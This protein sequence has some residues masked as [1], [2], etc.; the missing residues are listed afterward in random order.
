MCQKA[1]SDRNEKQLKKSTHVAFGKETELK[2]SKYAQHATAGMKI[3]KTEIIHEYP[4]S[5]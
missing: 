4:T 1:P 5:H 2:V 3:G